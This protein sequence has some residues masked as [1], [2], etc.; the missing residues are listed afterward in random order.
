MYTTNYKQIMT[1]QLEH[2][3]IFSREIKQKLKLKIIT[4]SH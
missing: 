4:E 3:L 1:V 2:F